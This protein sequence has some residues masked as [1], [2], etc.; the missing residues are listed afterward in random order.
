MPVAVR[1]NAV[2]EAEIE[3]LSNILSACPRREHIEDHV[4]CRDTDTRADYV[5][6][7]KN[8]KLEDLKETLRSVLSVVEAARIDIEP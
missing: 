5:I 1:V 2:R 3:N 7:I 6:S 8:G 4:V